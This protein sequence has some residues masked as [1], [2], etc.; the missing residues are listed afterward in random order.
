MERRYRVNQVLDG[1]MPQAA[2]RHQKLAEF[3]K[4]MPQSPQRN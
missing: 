2:A 3:A 4:K 1:S